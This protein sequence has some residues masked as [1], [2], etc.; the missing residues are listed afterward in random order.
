MSLA[1]DG[2]ELDLE[3]RAVGFPTPSFKWLE[4]DRFVEGGTQAH[5]RLPRLEDRFFSESCRCKCSLRNAY[6][7]QVWNEVEENTEWAAFYRQGNKQFA[8]QLESAV[9][10]LV[11][12]I[13]D[14]H[15]EE[16]KGGGGGD[17]VRSVQEEGVRAAVRDHGRHERRS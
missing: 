11:P 14:D 4:N 3:C 6:K 2:L 1:S 17:R 16:A 15:G 13:S 12:F 8:S 5:L 9:V 10:D 7:C